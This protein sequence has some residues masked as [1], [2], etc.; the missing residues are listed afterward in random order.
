MAIYAWMLSALRIE[1]KT[2]F[3]ICQSQSSRSKAACRS[4]ALAAPK[5]PNF[6][7]V[8]WSS[9]AINGHMG[10]RWY[11]RS[12]AAPPS[13]TLQHAVALQNY[14]TTKLYYY[15]TGFHFPLA[16]SVTQATFAGQ[17]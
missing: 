9:C 2:V 15:K 5:Q 11:F 4:E 17:Q 12:A 13:W 8:P 1:L 3:A 14:T 16:G 10:N 6:S 7:S